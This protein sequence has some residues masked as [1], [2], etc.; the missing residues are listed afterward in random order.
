MKF[1]E[2]RGVLHCGNIPRHHAAK[3]TSLDRHQPNIIQ[4]DS[5]CILA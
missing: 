3:M 1:K 5:S 4:V 2:D